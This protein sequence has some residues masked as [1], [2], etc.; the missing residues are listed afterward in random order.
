MH[1]GQIAAQTPDKPAVIMA[2]SGRVV[3]FR[4]LNEESNRLAQLLRA[5][6]LRPGD[7]IAFMLENHPLYLAIAWA[8]QRSGLYYTAISSRLQ[9]EELA[10][11][12]ANCEAKVFIASASVEAAAKSA[13]DVPLRLMLGGT[14]PGYESYEERVARHPAT[15][16]EDECEG[17][18]MLYSSGTTG[19]PKG[20]KPPLS[21][22][23]MGEAGP[24]YML[25]STLFA[26]DADSVYLSPAPLYHAAPLRYSLIFHRLGATVVVMEKFDPEQALATIEK[27][28]V[29][30]SQWV[31]TMFIRMLKLP[32]ETRARYDVSSLACAVHAAAPCPVPVKERMI[33]WWGP[34]LHEYYAGTEGNCFVYTNSADWLTHKGTVGRPILGEVH[35]CDE[36]G[37]ELPAGEPGTLYFGNGPQFEYHADEAKTAASRDPQGRGWTTLGDVGYV[38]EDGFLYLTDRRAYMIIS[39]GVNIYP[40]EAE[41]VLA[42]HP[43]VAD[44]AVFGVPDAEMGEAVKAVVQPLSMDAAGPDLEAELIAYCRDH[45][46]HYKCPRSIDFRPELPRHPTG[47]LYKRLLKDEYWSE[48]PSAT[49]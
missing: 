38:D 42:V 43:K 49:A 16:I 7:H 47:K 35:V 31:P 4:E 34:I 33:D 12:V 3:T 19:R 36:D 24:L 2:G 45:L 14:A 28:R 18:D 39:G 8:A 32:D 48:K 1:L 21:K 13:P 17:M 23:P 37:N 29:T 30:H 27:Y 40:Q 46:A 44:V 11:I 5:E 25:I 22:A 6:G 9:P 41:N 10:Y 20:V 26:A 15:P